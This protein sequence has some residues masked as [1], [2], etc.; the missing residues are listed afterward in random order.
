MSEE[1]TPEEQI[2]QEGSGQI[3]A[4]ALFKELMG[5][6]ATAAGLDL[7]NVE[8][9][10]LQ[11]T[12]LIIHIPTGTPNLEDSVFEL[13]LPYTIVEFKSENDKF[14]Q[15]EFA[16]ILS[17]TL[18]FYA[19]FGKADYDEILTLFVCARYPESLIKH[20]EAN[21][22]KIETDPEN[23]WLL[24]TVYGT[25]KIAFVICRLLPLEEKF[26]RWLIFAPTDSIKWEE[27]VKMIVLEDKVEIV[28]F[29]EYFRYKEFSEMV[30][31]FETEIKNLDDPE[32][33]EVTKKGFESWRRIL[34]YWAEKKPEL[35]KR[36]VQSLTPEEVVNSFT[37][38]Q[39]EALL[40]LLTEPKNA[41]KSE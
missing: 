17:R 6:M 35:H 30:T 24:R 7:L 39:R 23:A 40:K 32:I 20:L 33:T 5:E 3:R 27:F 41:E 34:A 11:L 38:E 4:D 12:D 22:I 26:F 31:K 8:L 16:Q 9:P 37:P 1:I 29:F 25:L 18:L 15:F 21:G 10:R 2:D 36:Y 13:F 14:N 28:D 19:K